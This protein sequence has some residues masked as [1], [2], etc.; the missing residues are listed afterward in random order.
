VDLLTDGSTPWTALFDA[1]T[2]RL[3]RLGSTIHADGVRRL[4]LARSGPPAFGAI[5]RVIARH[6]GWRLLRAEGELGEPEFF[7][8][9]SRRRFPVVPRL[10][11]PEQTFSAIDP[12]YWHEVFGHATAILDPAV[13]ELYRWLGEAGTRASGDA[14]LLADVTRLYWWI[15]EYGFIREGGRPRAFG[16]ALVG[17]PV[18]LERVLAGRIRVRRLTARRALGRD[19]NP[20]VFQPVLFCVDSIPDALERLKAWY[21]RRAEARAG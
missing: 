14:S 5:S 11:P 20:H 9:L 12:D 2:P 19:A 3:S 7:E 17:S 13:A 6:T 18:A 10:R 16:A 1:V 4:G 21:A 8:A 15:A